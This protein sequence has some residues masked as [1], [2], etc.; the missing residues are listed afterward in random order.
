M[1]KLQISGKEFIRFDGLYYNLTDLFRLTTLGGIRLE[2]WGWAQSE[3]RTRDISRRGWFFKKS[4]AK[5]S[6][7][8]EY[9]HYLSPHLY[10]D[11]LRA[12]DM[13]DEE[14]LIAIL[15]ERKATR[16]D[17]RVE[18][19]LRRRQELKAVSSVLATKVDRKVPAEKMQRTLRTPTRSMSHS[20]SMGPSVQHHRS[21]PDYLT[22]AMLTQAVLNDWDDSSHRSHSSH[23]RHD[24]V[25]STPSRSSHDSHSSSSWSGD[26]GGSYDSG[27]SGGCD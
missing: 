5:V 26:S 24:D 2:P 15:G 27:S 9:A 7:L 12:V 17:L 19:F 8:I 18:S 23:S 14:K 22:Q 6:V 3:N 13:D 4:W 11:V 1:K 25:C 10:R 21:E 16:L 20:R